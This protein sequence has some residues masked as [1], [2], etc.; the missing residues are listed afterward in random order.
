MLYDEKTGE[1]IR[2]FSF[3]FKYRVHRIDFYG[4]IDI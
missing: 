2:S 3:K 1:I 4:L